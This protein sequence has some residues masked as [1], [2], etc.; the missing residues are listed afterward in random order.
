M[1]ILKRLLLILVVA[2]VLVAAM[3]FTTEN[4]ALVEVNL[5]FFRLEAAV[6]TWLL[7]SFVI[8]AL[9]GLLASSGLLVRLQHAKMQQGRQSRAFEKEVARLS[10]TADA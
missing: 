1:K 5:I 6:A 9:V 8:G 4:A 10:N 2:V 3:L 7:G